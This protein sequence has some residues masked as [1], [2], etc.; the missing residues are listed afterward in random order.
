MRRFA[1]TSL[2]LAALAAGSLAPAFAASPE[3][4]PAHKPAASVKL[5]T[6]SYASHR[7][8]FVARMR[9]VRGARKM[10]LRYKVLERFPGGAWSDVTPDKLK[11]WFSTRGRRGGLQHKARTGGLSEDGRYRVRVRFRWYGNDGQVLRRARRRSRTCHQGGPL[12]NLRVRVLG[13]QATKYPNLLRYAVRVTNRGAARVEGAQVGLTVDGAELD[14]KAALPMNPGQGRTLT[15]RGPV[16]EASVEAAAD[17]ADAV[18]ESSESD[19]RH[20]ATCADVRP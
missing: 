10:K 15:F 13:A 4:V 8:V 17:P 20:S 6:C 1:P 16:C 9:R 2:L 11:R 19:N 3:A 14:R 18:L 7:A 5:K 12:P